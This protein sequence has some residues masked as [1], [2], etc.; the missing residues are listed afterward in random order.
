MIIYATILLV[1]GLTDGIPTH[2]TSE[3]I[4]YILGS[5]VFGYI[6]LVAMAAALQHEKAGRIA[7]LEYVQIVFGFIFDIF[8]FNAV[9]GPS[10]ILGS[11]LIAVSSL[12]ITILKCT[13]RI[14]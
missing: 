13:N 10:E 6:G 2:Y 7:T 9:I 14:N 8:L 12:S 3:L 11:A 5:G 1:V 4:L